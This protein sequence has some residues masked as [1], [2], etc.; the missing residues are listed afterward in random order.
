LVMRLDH[1][2]SRFPCRLGAVEPQRTIGPK[3]PSNI[4]K[5]IVT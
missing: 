2:R 5:H 1:P 3:M 4:A